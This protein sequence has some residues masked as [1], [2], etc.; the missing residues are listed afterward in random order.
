MSRLL[1]NFAVTVVGVVGLGALAAPAQADQYDATV[2]SGPG[3]LYEECT[4]HPINYSVTPALDAITWSMRLVFQAPDGT[5]AGS[6]FISQG[7]PT[8][9]V[10]TKEFCAGDNIPGTYTVTGTYEVLENRG[11]VSVAKT[12][13]A[14][15]P[16]TFDLRLAQVQ[17]AAKAPKKKMKV[18]QKAR[19]SVTVSDERPSGGFFGS[20][21][22]EVE[23]Q[24]QKG[25]GWV[26]VPGASSTTSTSGKV[27]LRFK[28]KWKGKSKFRA[29]G[30][31]I[32]LG[33]AASPT[34]TLRAR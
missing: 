31:V 9:G 1:R 34:F 15:T 18:G 30:T 14:I 25:S 27:S 12:T 19:V 16:F 26:R 7:D 22:S 11:T 13:R 28:N 8:T 23:I 6:V 4:G 21:Y 10:E 33:T 20:A 2:T 5:A 3:V 29:V 32:D 17:V 24:R